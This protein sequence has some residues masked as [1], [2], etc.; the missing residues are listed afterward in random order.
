LENGAHVQ[1][2]VSHIFPCHIHDKWIYLSPNTT[3][4]MKMLISY[5][6]YQHALKTFEVELSKWEMGMGLMRIEVLHN[7]I[8]Q[9]EK[10]NG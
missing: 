7:T 5:I 4:E 3:F 10:E 9:W 6:S 1:R 8:L 2:E